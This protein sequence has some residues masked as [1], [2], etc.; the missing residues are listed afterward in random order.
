M[1]FP[2]SA[3]TGSS[4]VTINPIVDS[5]N[6]KYYPAAGVNY[7]G[8]FYSDGLYVDGPLSLT[9]GW[10]EP[11]SSVK[12]SSASKAGEVSK[13][14]VISASENAVPMFRRTSFKGYPQYKKVSYTIVDKEQYLSNRKNAGNNR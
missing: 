14:K 4:T 2:V 8:Y 12:K 5:E 11:A 13:A 3:A 1:A 9:K 6:N 10:I 7:S